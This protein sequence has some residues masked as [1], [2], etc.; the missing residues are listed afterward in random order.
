MI[1]QSVKWA[2]CVKRRQ[3]NLLRISGHSPFVPEQHLMERLRCNACGAYFTVTLPEAVLADGDV[4]QKYGYSARA[5]MGIHK[6]FAGLP[7]YRQGSLQQ[8][9]G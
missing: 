7:Y 8:L 1:A 6:Y 3:V 2:K 9:L 4:G 5:L